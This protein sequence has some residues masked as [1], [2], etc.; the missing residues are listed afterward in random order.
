VYGCLN[1]CMCIVYNHYGI[2][3]LCLSISS[4]SSEHNTYYVAPE[5]KTTYSITFTNNY[6]TW[7]TTKIKP[8]TNAQFSFTVLNTICS[9]TQ[10]MYSWRWAYRCLKHVELFKIINKFVHQVGTSR[11]FCIWCTDTHTH[12]KLANATWYVM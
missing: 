4:H 8:P 1:G 12:I 11:H 6:T 3:P 9:N 7:R 10:L 5:P 2:P